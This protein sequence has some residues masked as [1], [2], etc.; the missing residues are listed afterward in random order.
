MSGVGMLREDGIGRKGAST[1]IEER[2]REIFNALLGKLR[3]CGSHLCS[4]LHH[5]HLPLPVCRDVWGLW[6]R[7]RDATGSPL[8][9]P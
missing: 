5:H 7:D 3:A 6:S 4:S 8:D 2:D 9:G 1:R